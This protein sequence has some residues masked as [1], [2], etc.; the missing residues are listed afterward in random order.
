MIVGLTFQQAM[1]LGLVLTSCDCRYGLSACYECIAGLT[2]IYEL[3]LGFSAG[4][5][6]RAELIAI[7]DYRNDPSA[8][9]DC[10]AGT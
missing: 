10:R 3:R 6:C 5:D 8:G 7:Y 9:H 2:E 4:H 1:I